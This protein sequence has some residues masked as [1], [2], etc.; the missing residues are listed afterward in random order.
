[1]G[2]RWIAGCIWGERHYGD[3]MYLLRKLKQNVVGEG[4][5]KDEAE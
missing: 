2:K 3:L 1:M 5:N 4:N